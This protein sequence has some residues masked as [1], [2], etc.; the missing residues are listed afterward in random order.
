MIAATLS[1]VPRRRPPIG[2]IRETPRRRSAWRPSRRDRSP[3]SA[4]PRWSARAPARP[5]SGSKRGSASARRNSSKASSACFDERLA[6][7]RRRR[8]GRH[9][10]EFDGARRQPLLEGVA[11]RRR[12]RPRRGAGPS[13]WATPGLSAGSCAAPPSKAKAKATSGTSGDSTCQASTPPGETTCRTGAG[14]ERVST[15][16][17][18]HR[19]FRGQR[20]LSDAGRAAEIARHRAAGDEERSAAATRSARSTASISRGQRR[21]SSS[22][23]PMARAEP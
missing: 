2:M 11:N 17:S 12:R 6:A 7:S 23:S 21:T 15:E 19:E 13:I 16:A 9:E 1:A 8:R 20:R 4:G 22:V 5:A 10:G 3:G 14:D 18:R